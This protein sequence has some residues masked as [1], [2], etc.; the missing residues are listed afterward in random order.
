MAKATIKTPE[1][2]KEVPT[3]SNKNVENFDPY[4][5]LKHPISTEKSIRQVEYDNKLVFVVDNKATKAQVKKAIET[6]FK[7]RVIKVNLQNS[8]TGKKK[9]YIKLG[10]E[11][12]AS[13]IGADL[14]MI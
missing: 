9:A 12:L 6:L 13:D 1:K 11:H 8:I 3:T 4:A 10:K 14:G 5:I 2:K 7:V